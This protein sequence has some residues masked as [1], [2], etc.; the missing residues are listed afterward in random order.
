MWETIHRHWWAT[1]EFLW[2][3]SNTQRTIFKK[4]VSKLDFDR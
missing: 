3:Y 4:L 2:F 1:V